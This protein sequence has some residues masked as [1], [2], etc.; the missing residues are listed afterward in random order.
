[1]ISIAHMVHPVIVPDASDLMIAQPVTFSTMDTARKF[2]AESIKVDLFAVQYFDE[3]RIALPRSFI[4]TH[5]LKRSV[6]DVARFRKK[7]KLALIKD[8]LDILYETGGA[9]YLIYTNVDIAL[10]PYFYNVVGKIIRQGHDAF[11]INRR[12]IPGHYK[13]T[14]EIPLMYA[15]SGKNHPGWD[16]FIFHRSMYPAFQLGQVCVGSGWFG[17]AMIINMATFAK[18]FRIF[19]DMQA[20]FHI[21]NDQAWKEPLWEDYLEHN[22]NECRRIMTDFNN[23]YGPFHHEILKRFFSKL[24]V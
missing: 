14:E 3:E 18:N 6:G 5:D 7:R 19:T 24:D 13:K 8:V 17:R 11:I 22:K 21:G 16:C 20:T 15:E 10:Q 23:H 12:T 2:V 9:D 4:R 1:M